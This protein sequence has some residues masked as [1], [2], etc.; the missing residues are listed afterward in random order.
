MDSLLQVNDWSL[1]YNPPIRV[2]II[3]DGKDITPHDIV[4]IILEIK[5]TELDARIIT[6]LGEWDGRE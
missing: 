1:G 6:A 2:S 4:E 5:G 3:K